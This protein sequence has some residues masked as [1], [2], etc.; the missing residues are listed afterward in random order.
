M[1]ETPN[2]GQATTLPITEIN[3]HHKNARLG[4]VEA[5]KGSMVAN[6]VY[7]P[8]VVNRGT[9]TGRPNEVLAGNHSLKAM[10]Q[11][12][13]ANPD[14]PRWQNVD[15]WLVDVDEERATRILLADNRTADMGDY[16]TGVLQELL[17]SVD[18][19]LDGTGY[20]YDDL[21][22]LINENSDTLNTLKEFVANVEDPE[23]EPDEQK[24]Q[25]APE[26]GA[27]PTEER[28]NDDASQPPT[29]AD[30]HYEEY[31]AITFSVTA[32]ERNRIRIALNHV[33]AQNNLETQAQALVWLIENTPAL[34]VDEV[35]EKAENVIKA[36]VEDDTITG[37]N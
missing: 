28:E 8:L 25:P 26:P 2:I 14:D 17:E 30:L 19:D 18:H 7:K 12:A 31:L 37:D 1:T 29:G 13:E 6:G 22:E 34:N 10:R 5:I 21:D 16:D 32:E 20:D 33:K 35:V 11:L 15:V 36:D 23:P 3:L 27:A 9:H 4:D 24:E